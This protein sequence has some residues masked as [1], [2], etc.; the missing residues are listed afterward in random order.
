MGLMPV[1]TVF[2]SFAEIFALTKTISIIQIKYGNLE[3]IES[4]FAAETQARRHE[5]LVCVEQMHCIAN[6][7]E[8]ENGQ[9]LVI[10]VKHLFES[11]LHEYLPSL[12]IMHAF[13]GSTRLGS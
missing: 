2:F 3:K 9:E 10:F 1:S 4:G 13:D 11:N 8:P 12:R 6:G 5:S 7:C